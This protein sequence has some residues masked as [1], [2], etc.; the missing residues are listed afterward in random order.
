MLGTG[1]NMEQ[2]VQVDPDTRTT[3]DVN[4]LVGPEQDVSCRVSSDVPI[5]AERPMYFDF[6][7][8]NGGHDV[9]GDPR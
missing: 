8:Y 3:I 7:G 1:E 6:S 9:M 2:V 4:S 5:V